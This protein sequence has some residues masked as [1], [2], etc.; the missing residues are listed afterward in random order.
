MIETVIAAAVATSPV[1]DTY[2]QDALKDH[3][4]ARIEAVKEP[5]EREWDYKCGI[6]ST[7]CKPE[8]FQAL[9]HCYRVNAKNGYGAYTGWVYWVL[10]ERDGK[11]FFADNIEYRYKQYCS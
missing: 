5:S 8:K 3:A 10:G 1:V 9:T 6:F 4:T 2:F 11:I 7:K